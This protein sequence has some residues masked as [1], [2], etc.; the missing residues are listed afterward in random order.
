LRRFYKNQEF[1][2]RLTLPREIACGVALTPFWRISL[3]ADIV[4]TRWSEFGEWTFR[5]VSPDDALSPNW[6]QVYEDFYGV[7]PD[8]G[9]QA[10][11]RPRG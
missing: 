3:C 5:A 4:W 2:G 7:G 1:T 8:Y 6:T 11:L 9:T 10:F